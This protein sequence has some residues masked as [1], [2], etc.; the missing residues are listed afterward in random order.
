MALLPGFKPAARWA[1]N[2]GRDPKL[3]RPG[4]RVA[5]LR[6]GRV[7]KYAFLPDIFSRV[8]RLGGVLGH[9]AYLLAL[10]F[11][12]ARLLPADHPMLSALNIGRFG[13]IDVVSEA[14]NNLVVSRK[15]I[16]QIMIFGAIVMGVVMVILQM[17]VI[18]F[19]ALLSPQMAHASSSPDSSGGMF[20]SPDPDNDVVLTFLQQTIGL[21]GFFNNSPAVGFS[22]G[23][24]LHQMLGFYSTALMIIATI[25]V[26]YYVITVVGESAQT[27]QP[28][29]RRFNGLW[30]PVR[31]VLAL[32]LLVPLG[33]G[34]NAAQ[35]TAL[36]VAKMGSGLA[37]QA[38][39]TFGTELLSANSAK[40][41]IAPVMADGF[42]DIVNTIFLYQVCAESYNAQQASGALLIEPK[43]LV[44]GKPGA[45]AYSSY[46]GILF[47][48]DNWVVDTVNSF[49]GQKYEID[50]TNYTE[51][52]NRK[53]RASSCGTISLRYPVEDN[54]TG[55]RAV[56]EV[57][58]K[59]YS[60]AII[61]ASNALTP[62]AKAYARKTTP[63][64]DNPTYNSD[65]P[66]NEDIK[67]I[68]QDVAVIRKAT[69][70]AD[71]AIYTALQAG[72]PEY[73]EKVLKDVLGDSVTE[74]G[75]GNAGSYYMKIAFANQKV[76]QIVQDAK[77]VPDSD[78]PNSIFH[79]LGLDSSYAG[80]Q[81]K[82]MAVSL[83]NASKMLAEVPPETTP[84]LSE[85]IKKMRYPLGESLNPVESVINVILGGNAFVDL[86]DPEMQ[87][88]S[89]MARLSALGDSL[90]VKAMVAFGAGAV[91]K[92]GSG[93]LDMATDALVEGKKHK[94]AAKAAVFSEILDRLAGVFFFFA[95]IGL[96]AGFLLF[97]VLPFL[98]FIYFFFAIVEWGMSV[99]EAMV[100]GPL[101]ALAHL[102][103]DG[104]GM[105]GQAAMNGYVI[106]F[107]MLIRP[108]LILFGL[109]AS[110]I[111]FGTGAQLLNNVFGGVLSVA[112][113]GERS[114]GVFGF[115]GYMVLYAIIV[116]N[117]GLVCFK[118]IDQIPAQSMRWLG[119]S[120]LNYNDGK[121]DP[122]GDM[123]KGASAAAAIMGTQLLSSLKG[124]GK[125]RNL[126]E[127]AVRNAA[128][129]GKV[130]DKEV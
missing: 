120:N 121:A 97:Y 62:L 65:D 38:W 128:R 59:A 104:E 41:L 48:L 91:S 70:D 77:P 33:N 1:A 46:D 109:L 28:F 22:I 47:G 113:E 85:N 119:Q 92:I 83:A 49:M 72:G 30:A 13:L 9:F 17:V 36:T 100:G 110:Y 76:A 96:A 20:S 5:R 58:M 78:K 89:P 40:N 24:A 111:V 14:A 27:G 23:E 102:R 51:G 114:L 21:D 15:N 44:H 103:I 84:F 101:W 34:L 80:E 60:Q 79:Y 129:R 18:V 95:L 50:W 31:L 19:Y 45:L 116:Y 25:I 86:I 37:T 4:D 12:S 106:L 99:L 42:S 53:S 54:D 43:V 66:N 94:G 124:S 52:T 16:D 57:V 98:P 71:E 82:A 7:L 87:D 2:G 3:Q 69:R 107:G 67:L 26:I 105:P 11:R 8:R 29:G 123:S 93:A 126:T 75:W 130:E 127:S 39:N 125:Q 122:I 55:G 115:A 10:I 56:A 63:F 81:S 108:F 35:Y 74:G 117:L 73:S 61:N 90:F 32:G 88:I 68:K 64:P 118:M 112:T 6:F